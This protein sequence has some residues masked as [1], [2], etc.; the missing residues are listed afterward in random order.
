[1]VVRVG[2][3]GITAIAL[4]LHGDVDGD[5]VRDEDDN[6]PLTRNRSSIGVE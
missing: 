1:L 3:F 2:L 6:Y 5:G 4:D